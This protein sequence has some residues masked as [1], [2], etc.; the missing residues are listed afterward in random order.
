MKVQSR[1][2]SVDPNPV[3]TGF[4][5]IIASSAASNLIVPVFSLFLPLLALQ[6]GANVLEIGLV[7]GASNMVYSFMP[8]VMG[9]LANTSGARRFFIVLSLT[10]LSIISF[11]Y[12]IANSP[13][14]LILLRLFEGLGWATFWPAVEA[15]L[16]HDPT[17]DPKRTLTIFNFSWSGAAAIGPLFGSF[18]VLVL[19]IRESFLATSILLFTTMILNLIWIWVSSKNSRA[20]AE[21]GNGDTF[22]EAEVEVVKTESVGSE[23]DLGIPI[24]VSSSFYF[25]SM[26]LCAVSSGILFSFFPPFAR[27]TGI[28]IVM[29][30]VAPFVFGL[31]R[32]VFYYLTIKKRIKNF[33]FH[34]SKRIR[35][36]LVSISILS[37]SSL[38]ITLPHQSS[39]GIYLIPFAVAGAG[40]SIV[41]S[42]SQV[43][44]LAEVNPER[45]G[46]GAG[47]FESS[48]GVGGA[49][50]P[51]IAGII[52]GNSLSNSFLAPSICLLPVLL[53]QFFILKHGK[54]NSTKTSA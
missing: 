38:L 22:A 12:F 26:A 51:V 10:M 13:L 42:I 24:K 50:G 27:S 49:T 21:S 23:E 4:L 17:R 34:H 18:L 52:S 14:T 11:L 47:L 1:K 39:T 8:F 6:L 48:I 30:G 36:V 5:I 44:M 33:L 7:G 16:T 54:R 53:I 31:S 28:S 15:T 32:F 35:N 9:R 40:Y 45:M 37:L 3:N 46:T 25:A 2:A 19:S 41:Y 43:A 29:I 20:S